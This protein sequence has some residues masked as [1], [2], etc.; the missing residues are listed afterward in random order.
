MKYDLYMLSNQCGA[1][2][3]QFIGTF[4]SEESAK[5]YALE[6]GIYNYNIKKKSNF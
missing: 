6:S 3:S 5:Q 1:W 4:D 2:V